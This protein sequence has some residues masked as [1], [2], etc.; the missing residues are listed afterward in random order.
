M[1]PH[2]LTLEAFGPYVD[3]VTIEFDEL[4]RD[5][6][7]LIHGPTGAG[8]TYLLDAMSFALY[9]EVAGDRGTHTL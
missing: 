8:K 2:R 1:K 7:F 4:A 5:G 9:G 6:L 3:P